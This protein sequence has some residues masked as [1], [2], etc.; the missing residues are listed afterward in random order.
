MKTRI[1][2]IDSFSFDKKFPILLKKDSYFAELI[3]LNA[4]AAVFHSSVHSGLNYIHSNYWIVKRR[5]TIK[6]LL[7]RC[8]ICEYVQGKSLLRPE[9][10][11][12]LEFRVNAT[13]VLNL[14]ESILLLRFI[15]NQGIK[16]IKPAYYYLRAV[17]YQL[18]IL[19]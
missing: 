5:Q 3:V 16:F 18:L 2:G 14:L 1:S 15:I 17:L 19:S 6:Q 13:V 12:L 8:F 9:V 11:L 4:H 10:L 7:K